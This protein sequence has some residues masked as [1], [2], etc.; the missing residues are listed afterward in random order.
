MSAQAG[1]SSCC[2]PDCCSTD[3]EV[4]VALKP[5]SEN[6]E[7]TNVETKQLVK[8]KYAEVVETTG[9]CCGPACCGTEFDVSESYAGKDGYVAEAD[10]SL[11]C[12]IPT[13]V[14]EIKEGETVVD[15]GSGAG[16][17]V[18]VAR[19]LVGEKGRV[20]GVDFTPAMVRKART[21]LAKLGF[22]N[23]EFT[24]GDIEDIPLENGVAD[25][26]IS[27]CVLNLVPDKT[28]AFGEMHR[29]LKPGGRFAISDI[30]TVGEL[31]SAAKSVAELYAGCV[32]GAVRKEE[33]VA[34]LQAAGFSDVVIRKEKPYT[35]TTELLS[36]YLKPEE[37][38]E[39]E[40][41]GG[42]IVSVT[43]TGR[44]AD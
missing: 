13:D 5:R 31:P 42:R 16:N 29:I 9:S 40:K 43:V 22:T 3:S 11:G 20:I 30:V 34:G 33:Y 23:V 38:E 26:I 17:D 24:Q 6:V 25:I 27:N 12:G 15:L 28:K 32:S 44:R 10:Y 37:V 2:G 8:E 14:S 39:Y 35:L 36:K 19:S 18:F 7:R 1:Q 4:E 41:S 21:N